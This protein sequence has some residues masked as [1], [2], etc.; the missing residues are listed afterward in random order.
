MQYFVRDADAVE[1]V[2]RYSIRCLSGTSGRSYEDRLD[3]GCVTMSKGSN[4][5]DYGVTVVHGIVDINGH[6]F[7]WNIESSN[8]S[9]GYFTHRSYCAYMECTLL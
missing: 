1:R 4:V 7:K 2:W 6:R 8:L 3:T 9:F 5:F